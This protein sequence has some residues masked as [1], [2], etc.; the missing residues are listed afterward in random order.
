MNEV[1]LAQKMIMNYFQG[2]LK[3]VILQQSKKKYWKQ[4]F[5]K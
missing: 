4:Y 5:K 1:E 3:K 2:T